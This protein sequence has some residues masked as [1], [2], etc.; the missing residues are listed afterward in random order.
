[1]AS[2]VLTRS[3][4]NGRSGANLSETI[5]SPALVGGKGLI[6]A[7]S[8]NLAASPVGIGGIRAVCWLF[9]PTGKNPT[10]ELGPLKKNGSEFFLE[11]REFKV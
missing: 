1:M 3:Y 7:R 5:L 2:P 6:R 4:D 11:V 8:F 10:P 9:L